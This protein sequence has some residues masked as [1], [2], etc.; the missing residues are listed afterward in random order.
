VKILS[1]SQAAARLDLGQSTLE[2]WR[3]V[4]SGPK[5]IKLGTRRVGYSEA[6]LD[7]WIASR[8]RRT[9]TS[10][11]DSPGCSAADRDAAFGTPRPE[12][13]ELPR[14]RGRPRDPEER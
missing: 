4:G 8:P 13:I 3:C 6:D 14:R 9:S 11:V 2:K 10:E 5:F 12:K 1:T 7:A